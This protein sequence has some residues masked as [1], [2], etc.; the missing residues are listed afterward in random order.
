MIAGDTVVH[1]LRCGVWQYAIENGCLYASLVQRFQCCI[2]N[3]QIVEWL[4]GHYQ[5]F[6]Q[7]EAANS[8]AQLDS[9]SFSD[10]YHGFWLRLEEE[11]AGQR[12]AEP[13]IELFVD[14]C[15]NKGLIANGNP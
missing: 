14:C 10:E 2:E 9:G 11:C 6:T 5:N 7:T 3:P 13:K 12:L 4:I 1:Y 15:H 8:L